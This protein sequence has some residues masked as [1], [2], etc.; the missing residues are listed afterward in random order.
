[1]AAE[2][3][4]EVL[5]WD[6]PGLTARDKVMLSHVEDR[7]PSDIEVR[8]T[9]YW[10]PGYTGYALVADCGGRDWL[11]E[12]WVR[13]GYRGEGRAAVLLREVLAV[14]AG[15]ELELDVCP[16]R[17]ENSEPGGLDAS[18]LAAW[19]ARH[20]FGPAGVCG[21]D[22]TWMTRPAGLTPAPEGNLPT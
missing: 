12:L 1:V 19:Y 5:T 14:S 10:L 15:R 2:L 20:G 22:E 8:V 3:I 6:T 4:R 7:I 13:P 11:V 21:P 17:L 9:R 18:Q 16:F